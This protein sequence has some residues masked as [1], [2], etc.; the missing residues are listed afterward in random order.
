MLKTQ[1]IHK[2]MLLFVN[3]VMSDLS[4]LYVLNPGS[5][6]HGWLKKLV[7]VGGSVIETEGPSLLRSQ[8][9]VVLFSLSLAGDEKLMFL[10]KYLVILLISKV[11]RRED[12]DVIGVIE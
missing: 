1:R 6:S 11:K 8:S 9:E 3:S 12:R 4:F 2:S 5:L 7:L 10:T